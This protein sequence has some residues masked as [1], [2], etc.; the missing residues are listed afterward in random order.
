MT[1]EEKAKRL[2]RLQ[3]RERG[4]NIGHNDYADPLIASRKR[5]RTDSVDV[6]S[7]HSTSENVKTEQLLPEKVKTEII[8]IESDEEVPSKTKVGPRYIAGEVLLTAVTGYKVE[9]HHVTFNDLVQKSDLT[10]GVFSAFQIDPDW[11]QSKL[12]TSSMRT[13]VVCQCKDREMVCCLRASL[14]TA[15]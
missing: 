4:D 11:L 1:P 2:D 14:I 15:R 3:K 9:P 13:Y 12:L 5:T 8:E 10:I 6:N 7:G